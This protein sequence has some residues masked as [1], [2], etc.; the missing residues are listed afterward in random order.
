MLNSIHF[1]ALY[2]VKKFRYEIRVLKYAHVYQCCNEYQF[3]EYSAEYIR[4]N[5][6]SII[7]FFVCLFFPR[8]SI[9]FWPSRIYSNS[10]EFDFWKF[11]NIRIRSIFFFFL[12]GNIRIRTNIN[13]DIRECL[14]VWLIIKNLW[15]EY[16][17][18]QI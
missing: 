15:D 7:D 12:S 4:L 10:F 5:I 8:Y 3:S 9:I 17:N 2:L 1:G 11:G 18:W 14:R 13:G 6:C 16:S